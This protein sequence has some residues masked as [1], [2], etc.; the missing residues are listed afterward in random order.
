[1]CGYWYRQL[2]ILIVCTIWNNSKLT[3]FGLEKWQFHMIQPII[4]LSAITDIILI[5]KNVL[6]FVHIL[7]TFA[8]R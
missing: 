3:L 2:F 6:Y 1:M 8:N 5:G 7:V 4:L